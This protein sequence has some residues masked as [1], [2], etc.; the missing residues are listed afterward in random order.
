[1]LQ[2]EGQQEPEVAITGKPAL[3][4]SPLNRF[5]QSLPPEGIPLTPSEQAASKAVERILAAG[6]PV[7]FGIDMAKGFD[8]QYLDRLPLETIIAAVHR[9]MP[10]AVV[11]CKAG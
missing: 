9:R 7:Y 1:M 4:N 6:K 8:E 11:V 5:L 3:K 2:Q 10:G